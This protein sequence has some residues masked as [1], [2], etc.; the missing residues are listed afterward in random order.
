VQDN[1][2]FLISYLALWLL[3]IFQTLVLLELVRRVAS[4]RVSAASEEEAADMLETGTP[5]PIFDAKEVLTGRPVRSAEYAGR[6]TL[7][8]FV[9]PGCAVCD[10]VTQQV[11]V[12]KEQLQAQLLVVCMAEAPA[13]EPYATEYRV[14][15]T[16]VY[17]RDHAIAR[18][19]KIK[20]V[21]TAV[22]V[23]RYGLIERYGAPHTVS[24]LDFGPDL[25]PP[26]SGIA[27]H[28]IEEDAV[29]W[30]TALTDSPGSSPSRRP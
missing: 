21:P 2:I 22:V 8:L 10:R 29:P 24:H 23:N 19:F 5:A 28:S 13:C 1:P 4:G 14:A 11:L 26:V 30:K 3:V 25:T 16:T 12:I 7:L 6:P 17:D 9:S 27:G 15:F 20:Q 18:S